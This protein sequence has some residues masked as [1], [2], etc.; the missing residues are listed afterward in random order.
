MSYISETQKIKPTIEKYLKNC[1]LDIGCGSYKVTESACGI[2]VRKTDAVD[3]VVPSIGKLSE[4]IKN[5]GQFDAV[6]S[7]HCLEHLEDDKGAIDDWLTLVK[8]G[9]YL[10]LYLPDVDYYK[11]DNPD[12]KHNY[13]YETFMNK[14]NYLN[15]VDSGLDASKPDHYSFFVVAKKL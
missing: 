3:I 10:V 11:E 8:S 5:L 15:V 14:F 9:G 12:H 4:H 7:S 1:I 6:F 2:D 13:T